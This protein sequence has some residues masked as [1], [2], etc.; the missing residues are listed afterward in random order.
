MSYTNWNADHVLLAAAPWYHTEALMMTL[1]S[2]RSKN[3]SIQ[4]NR[5]Q[6]L[7]ELNQLKGGGPFSKSV[8][9]PADV[10]YVCELYEDWA[11]QLAQLR[12]AC[13]YKN[14]RGEVAG[15]MPD[16]HERQS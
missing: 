7:A 3:F 14:R 9:F 5:N 15:H 4:E 8:R 13:S 2:L 16:S 11:R 1:V 10:K 12:S 6:A